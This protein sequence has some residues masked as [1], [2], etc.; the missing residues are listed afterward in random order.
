MKLSIIIPCY[1]EEDSVLKIYEKILTEL[2]DIKIELI[3]IDD[4][5]KDKTIEKLK[6][7][8]DQDKKRVRV[9]SF[10]RNFN[11][12][13]AI[14]AGLAHSTG[15]YT[16]II[17]ADL[18]Q[19]PRYL[20]EMITC[21]DENPEYDQVVMKM[22]RRNTDNMIMKVFKG[23]FYNLIDYL[24]DV[25][26]EKDASDFRMF[27]KG[28]VE[29]IL[30]MT[31]NNRFSK[32]LFAW[33]GYKTKY[34]SYEVEPRL[35]GK[36]KFNFK[37]SFRYAL[38][39]IVGYTVKPLLF[40]FITGIGLILGSLIYFI[41]VLFQGVNAYQF[42]PLIIIVILMSGIQLIA[43]GIIGEYIS[44]L[45]LEIKNRPI[46]IARKKWGFEDDNIL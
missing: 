38:D 35:T 2:K 6:E 22:A 34:L 28:I 45:Y 3:F 21:L 18:Q 33:V 41:I 7:L 39:G 26:F 4:G 27:R 8:Y 44:K 30:K 24:S 46:Y 23:I 15:E 19:N 42:A 10:S 36:T 40:A 37:N 14:Y 17:D 1:N 43:L 31:E 32:G 29:S 16:C 20:T 9:I 25:H 5:S 13:A 12:E 11:K